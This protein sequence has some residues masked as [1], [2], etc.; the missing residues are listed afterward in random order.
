MGT[1]KKL[2]NKIRI[3]TFNLKNLALPKVDY[4]PDEHYSE[5]V[6]QKKCAWTARQLDA[7]GADLVVL[8]EVFHKE[9]LAHAISLSVAASKA[10]PMRIFVP[11]DGSGP[12]VSLLTRYEVLACQWIAD[13][14]G[15]VN[16]HFNVD[17]KPI[18]IDGKPIEKF[19]RPVLRARVQFPEIGEGIVYGTHL[20][21]KSPDE[22]EGM[23]GD[24]KN[25]IGQARSLIRRAVEAA[26]LRCL[27]LRDLAPPACPAPAATPPVILCG[28]CNDDTIAVTT[29]ILCG[30]RPAPWM[31][32]AEAVNAYAKLMHS[33]L[34]LHS[35]RSLYSA[36][37]TYIHGG[38]YEALDHIFLSDHFSPSNKRRL[39]DVEYVRFLTDHLVDELFY[40]DSLPKDQSD[41]GQVVV[42]IKPT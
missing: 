24:L 35:S 16:E 10:P 19:S 41:H 21:S 22:T 26:G 33:A 39:G 1:N 27:L 4:Y 28:D 5:E 8:Q 31:S 32:G 14:P 34:E 11:E 38:L 15:E 18:S 30:E 2:D 12:K 23:V 42:T 6:Y 40:R 36:Y 29:R 3:G 9:A 20:K 17:G 37:Y 25:P 13:I 7:M